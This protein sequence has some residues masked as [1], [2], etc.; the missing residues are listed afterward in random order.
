MI[1]RR[2]LRTTAILASSI[3]SLVPHGAAKAAESTDFTKKLRQ[4]VLVSPSL[5]PAAASAGSDDPPWLKRERYPWKKD[6]VTTTFWIGEKPC[7]RNPVPNQS[8]SWDEKWAAN[9]GG[10]DEP[11][12]IGRA[13]CRE[14]VYSSV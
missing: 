14:R 13:S 7:P 6:I 10:T 1:R 9:Y 4:S 2:I 3:G 5:S 12:Q 8:S 11:D